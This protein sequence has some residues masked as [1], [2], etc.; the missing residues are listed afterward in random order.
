MRT[1]WI[2]GIPTT[3]ANSSS[4]SDGQAD[5]RESH[6]PTDDLRPS[7]AGVDRRPYAEILVRHTGEAIQ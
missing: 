2:H 5:A 6:L 3:A 4:P 7:N 1:Y